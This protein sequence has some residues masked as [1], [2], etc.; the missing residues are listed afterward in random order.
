MGKEEV[1]REEEDGKTG[2]APLLVLSIPRRGPS[3]VSCEE[4][5]AKEGGDEVPVLGGEGGAMY[6]SG[7]GFPLSSP[8]QATSISSPEGVG[9]TTK[10]KE[11]A[12]ALSLICAS[13]SLPLPC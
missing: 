8:M 9:S 4:G 12:R 2:T 3:V 5:S 13:I 10:G 1:E 11:E 6:I 7:V